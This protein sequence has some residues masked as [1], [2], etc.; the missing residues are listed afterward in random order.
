MLVIIWTQTI[1]QW[2]GVV[3]AIEKIR[4]KAFSSYTRKNKK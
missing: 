3:G 4:R 2:R 1:L